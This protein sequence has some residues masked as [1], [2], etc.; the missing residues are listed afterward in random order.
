MTPAQYRIWIRE[1][2]DL[3]RPWAL[4]EAALISGVRA[5]AGGAFDESELRR[6]MEWNLSQD[7]IRGAVNPD[8]D[9]KEWRLTPK[10]Q[11]KQDE[12]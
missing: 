2:L 12:Q 4:P 6:A 11:A 7:Y 9:L 1:A 8:T 10:G 3:A 5:L